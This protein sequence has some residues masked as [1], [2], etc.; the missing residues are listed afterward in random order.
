MAAPVATLVNQGDRFHITLDPSKNSFFALMVAGVYTGGSIG[1]FASPNGDPV[2]VAPFFPIVFP[3]I[4]VL[5]DP[6]DYNSPTGAENG[7]TLTANQAGTWY[8]APPTGAFTDFEVVALTALGGS[9][10][11]WFFPYVFP[12]NVTVSSDQVPSNPIQLL[13]GI[14]WG[15]E[16]MRLMLSNGFNQ[17]ND[18]RENTFRGQPTIPVFD[19]QP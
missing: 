4:P 14:Y 19:N 16:D 17:V 10:S 18:Y 2:T 13:Q 9:L 5:G 3:Y 1:F 15:L 11:V 7:R 6:M 12:L 8:F